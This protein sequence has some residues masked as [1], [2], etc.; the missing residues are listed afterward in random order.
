MKRNKSEWALI[1]RAT[2]GEKWERQSPSLLARWRLTGRSPSLTLAFFKI[3][4]KNPQPL[5][6]AYIVAQTQHIVV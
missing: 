6:F 5:R 4:L 1:F 2:S 3:L